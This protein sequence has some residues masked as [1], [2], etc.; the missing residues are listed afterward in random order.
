MHPRRSLQALTACAQVCLQLSVSTLKR[1]L[2][3]LGLVLAVLW[4]PITSHCAWEHLPGLQLFQC[5]PDTTPGASQ[6]SSPGSD[7]DGDGCAQLET[8]SY[9]V[10]DPQVDVQAPRPWLVVELFRLAR[11]P[12]EQPCPPTPVTRELPVRWQFSFRAALPPRAPS[13]VS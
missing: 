1:L 7:C 6:D 3:I 4:V 9:K 5:A 2:Q 12:L 10:S 8:A 13:I 11:P